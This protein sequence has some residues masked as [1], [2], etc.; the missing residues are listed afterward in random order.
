MPHPLFAFRLRPLEDIAPWSEPDGPA[1][2]WFGLTDGWFWIDAGDP[3]VS[4][5]EPDKDEA[6]PLGS[7]CEYQV[8]RLFDDLTEMAPFV[9]TEVPQPLHAFFAREAGR[10]WQNYREA[11]W[12]HIADAPPTAEG[13]NLLRAASEMRRLRTLDTSY[14]TAS[15]TTLMWSFEGQIHIK[16]EN[17]ADV[18]EGTISTRVIR[19]ARHLPRECFIAELRDFCERLCAAMQERI[20]KLEAN[21]LATGVRIDVAALAEEQE[22]RK[23]QLDNELANPRYPYDWPTVIATI[24]KLTATGGRSPIQTRSQP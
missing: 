21:G 5:C 7:V 20:G 19:A 3:Q 4:R 17:R 10:S 18:P 13:N 11:W 24:E 2:N 9:L 12:N 1:L 8:A 14:M 15:S 6:T 23:R 16:W 22:R